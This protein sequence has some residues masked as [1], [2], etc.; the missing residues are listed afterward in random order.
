VE[1][2]VPSDDRQIESMDDLDRTEHGPADAAGQPDDLA[3]AVADGADAMER[4]LDAGA[5]VV[6]ERPDMLDDER[7]VRL[8]DLA[9]QQAH[10]RIG[11]AGLGPAPEVHD[12]LDEGGPIREGV[13]RRHDLGRQRSEQ[14]IEIVDRFTG[15]L[16]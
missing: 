10:L 11:E 13:D 3:V 7:D 2:S 9:L 4:P 5:I 14:S 12:D 16:T 1:A 8:D 15:A 6:A